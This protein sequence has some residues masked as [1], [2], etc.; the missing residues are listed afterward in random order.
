MKN[1][2]NIIFMVGLLLFSLFFITSCVPEDINVTTPADL[3]AVPP[4]G[5]ADYCDTVE[6]GD[7]TALDLDLRVHIKNQG[8]TLAESSTVVVD[9][10]NCGNSV[11]SVPAIPAGNTV[12]VLLAMPIDCLSGDWGF[13]IIVDYY[14]DVEEGTDGEAN[15]S[16]IGNCVR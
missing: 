12:S 4:E 1:N 8:G 13:T 14:D 5:L 2:I 9:F 16:Q 6:T 3:I 10:G 11:Q 7:L 15:N